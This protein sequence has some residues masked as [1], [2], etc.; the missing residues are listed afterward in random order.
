MVNSR[1][2]G[3]RARTTSIPTNNSVRPLPKESLSDIT[4]AWK[5]ITIYLL[6][7]RIYDVHRMN[8]KLKYYFVMHGFVLRYTEYC[9]ECNMKLW[10]DQLCYA[11][12]DCWK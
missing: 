3:M 10:D 7:L 1:S 9:K 2:T 4:I 8:E 6:K 5:S 12:Y 11:E